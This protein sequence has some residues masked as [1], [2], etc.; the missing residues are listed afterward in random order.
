VREAGR[1]GY[2]VAIVKDRKD[3]GVVEK[4][5]FPED[6]EAPQGGLRDREGGSA[7]PD[8]G[9]ARR[10]LDGRLG[11]LDVLGEILAALA[12]DHLVAIAVA[13]DLVPPASNVPDE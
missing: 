7:I 13:A 1:V 6:F 11:P 3:A 10:V 2:P 12:V 4:A 8:H 9:G 5:R